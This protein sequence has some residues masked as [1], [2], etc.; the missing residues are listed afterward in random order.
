M[1][2]AEIV[3]RHEARGRAPLGSV[4]PP[5][6][7]FSARARA[8]ALTFG[9]VVVTLGV[10]WLA[11]SIVEWRHGRTASFGRTGL[12][13]VRRSTGKPIGL[14]RSVVRNGVCCTLLLV[15]TLLVCASLAFV[16]VMG[17]SPPADLLSTPRAAPWDRLTDTTVIDERAHT[18]RRSGLRLGRLTGDVR[19]SMN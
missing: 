15:P 17:A 7:S 8:L 9:L 6:A 16:F 4:G 19:V 10:G 13:V 5:E 11:W 12:R 3:Q 2:P 14:W 1:S 18:R